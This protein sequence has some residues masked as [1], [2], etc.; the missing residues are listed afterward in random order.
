[1]EFKEALEE[2]K[3]RPVQSGFNQGTLKQSEVQGP[4]DGAEGTIAR[5]GC[6]EG[7]SP[8]RL[9][10]PSMETLRALGPKS[11]KRASGEKTN[12]G[13]LSNK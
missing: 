13:I 4:G 2:P 11:P 3:R 10:S 8:P 12:M 5:R 6:G 1:M 9:L 7:Q